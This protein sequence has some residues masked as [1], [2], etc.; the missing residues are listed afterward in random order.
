M[1]E[2]RALWFAVV[3][4]RGGTQLARVALAVLAYQRTGSPAVTAL[5]YALTLLRAIIGG[6]FW[7]GWP[8]GIH[9]VN[10]WSCAPSRARVSSR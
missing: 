6:R 9:V 1:A 8:I 4:S 7:E 10:C 2:F 3:L 5:V